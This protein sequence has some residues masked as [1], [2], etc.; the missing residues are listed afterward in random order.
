MPIVV[1]DAPRWTQLEQVQLQV[2]HEVAFATDQQTWGRA[3]YWEPAGRSGDCEDIALLKR[4]RLMGLGWPAEAL[5]IAVATDEHGQLHAVL[6]VDV[7]G[8]D[9]RPESYAMDNRLTHVEPWGRLSE[10]GYRWIERQ[11]PGSAAWVSLGEAAIGQ[12]ASRP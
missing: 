10:L 1:L 8:A 9:G 11:K 6:T 12:V 7:T 5:R 3:E 4:Q 2:N